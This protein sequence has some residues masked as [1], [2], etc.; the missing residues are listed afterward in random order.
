MVV[1]LLEWDEERR[2]E[3]LGMHVR[4]QTLLQLLNWETPIAVFV[5]KPADKLE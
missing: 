2:I 4:F 5:K 1:D 3:E